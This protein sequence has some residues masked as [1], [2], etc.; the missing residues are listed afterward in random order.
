[1]MNTREINV[2]SFSEQGSVRNLRV[3]EETTNSFRVSWQAAPGSVIRYRLS[4]VP[5][6][7]A[8]EII[9]A[10]T[11]GPETSIVLQELFPITTYR[12]S[13]SPEY[14]TGLGVEMQV[15][16]T[17]KEGESMK[18]GKPKRSCETESRKGKC[19]FSMFL[20]FLLKSSVRGS[21]R[22]LRVFDE[23]TSTMKLA[24]RQAP[25]NVLRYQIIYKPAQGGEGNE[26]FVNGE[27]NE[28]ELQSLDPDTEYEL[29]VSAI[30]T[31]GSG[32]PLLGTGT[33]L[34]GKR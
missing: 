19:I 24:W 32:D 34:E 27:T 17:T 1:M 6:S 4:Y 30:Y 15:D 26:V 7:G 20:S 33:T 8:G 31:S 3:T 11:I 23:T 29:F 16:G 14:S 9:E 13:V 21:P 25:G 22:D 12:V 10:Q 28:V 18:S 2:L 5:L